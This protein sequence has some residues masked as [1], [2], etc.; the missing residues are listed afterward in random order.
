MNILINSIF[1]GLISTFIMDLFA[2]IKCR[3][4]KTSSFNYALLGRWVLSLKDLKFFYSNITQAPSRKFERIIGWF[5]HYVI[6]VI[7]CFI[8]IL[9]DD[10]KTCVD[11]FISSILFGIA[12]TSIPFLI[13]QPILGFGFFANKTLNQWVSIKNS[14][15]AHFYFGLGLFVAQFILKI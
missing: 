2:Y 5:L 3:L 14:L 1:L 12:T 9:I 15:I 11:T 10:S 6:G 4:F 8:Y 13:M 7:L